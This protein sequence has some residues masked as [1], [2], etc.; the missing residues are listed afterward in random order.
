MATAAGTVNHPLLLEVQGLTLPV[1]AAWP[2]HLDIWQ[3]PD[4]VARFGKVPVWSKAHLDLLRPL[5][6]M[7]AQAGQ[8]CITTTI[9]E[10]PWNHQTYDDF[11][12]MIKWTKRTNGDWS[13]D[14]T[15]FDTYVALAMECGIRAQINCYSMAPVGNTFTWFD[16]T[17]DQ[18]VKHVYTP[19]SPEYMDL[20]RPFLTAFRAHL[21]QKGWLGITAMAG[22]E[23]GLGEMEI[24]VKLLKATAPEFKIA[25]AGDHLKE[26]DSSIH[27]FS[28]CWGSVDAMSKGGAAAR[29]KLGHK[30]TFYTSCNISAPNTLHCSPTAEACYEGWFAAAMDFDGFLRWS[31]TSW[32]EDPN[33]DAR[34]ARWSAGDCWIVYPAARSSVRFERLREGIQDYEK[35]R[36][37]RRGLADCQ[38]PAAAASLKELND[39]LKSININTLS[40][41]SAAEVVNAGKEILHKATVT[42]ADGSPGSRDQHPTP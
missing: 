18:T 27:D 33:V 28:S 42:L 29:R 1:P 10:E 17:A 40:G 31:H 7:L 39:F 38:T 24:M 36:L 16:E 26:L 6:T 30:T 25:L 34:Y 22:D 21:E 35:I 23:R 37:L 2:F 32:P 19:G 41:F 15:H 11:G 4:A 12:G 5:L 8:K 20:W 3:H 13:Y 9:V 14:Y